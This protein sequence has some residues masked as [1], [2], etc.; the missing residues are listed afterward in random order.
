MVSGASMQIS[1][2]V[3]S[4]RSRDLLRACLESLRAHASFC[5]QIVVDNASGDDTSAMVSRHFSHVR[6]LS[7]GE[8]RGYAGGCNRGATVARGETLLFLNPDIRALKG[9][10][11]TLAAT[12]AAHEHAAAAGG[13]LLDPDGSPQ[14]RY[15]PRDLPGPARLARGLLMGAPAVAPPSPDRPVRQV[16]QV[17]G[18][19]L[20]VRR[21]IFRRLGGFDEQFHPVFFEDVD[22]CHRLGKAGHR[23]LHVPAAPFTHQGG[24][25]VRRMTPL[26]H[27]AAWFDN[28]VRYARK[29]H[30]S[31]PAAVLR[32]LTL[33][34]A[35]LRLAAT[36]TP[37]GGS[38]FGRGP[39]AAACLQIASR[40]LTGWPRPSQFTS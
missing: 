19:C 18:A 20:M 3:V 5:Q 28:L 40:S 4:W 9:S 24:G 7:L 13:L 30:G 1:I 32:A 36:L 14:A 11:S 34:A 16:A 22:L 38:P 15:G 8:N 26:D 37:R 2:I 23:I 35:T 27:Y 31:G 17:A 39:R 25:C 12:L 10:V 6:L 33:P 29:H 21:Q